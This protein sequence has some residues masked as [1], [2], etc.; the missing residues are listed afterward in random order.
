VGL[1]HGAISLGCVGTKPVSLSLSGGIGGGG[2]GRDIAK[3]A[4][5]KVDVRAKPE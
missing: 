2:G 4:R 5:R 3:K 1:L